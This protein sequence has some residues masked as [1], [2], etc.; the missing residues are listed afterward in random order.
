MCKCGKTTGDFC[1]QCENENYVNYYNVENCNSCGDSE[2]KC[3][4]TIDAKCVINNKDLD[5]LGVKADDKVDVQTLLISINNALQSIS[6]AL[7]VEY[8]RVID[9]ET[10]IASYDHNFNW[11]CVAGEVCPICNEDE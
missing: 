11:D 6:D 10:G 1:N 3:K 4:K 2:I 9:S 8:T 7:C 5:F